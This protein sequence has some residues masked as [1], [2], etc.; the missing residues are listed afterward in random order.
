MTVRTQDDKVAHTIVVAIAI[1]VSDFKCLRYAEPAQGA[2]RLVGLE[3]QFA[4]VDPFR[5]F[6][7]FS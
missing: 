7:S 1:H 6:I 3:R 2:E 5:H 4:V